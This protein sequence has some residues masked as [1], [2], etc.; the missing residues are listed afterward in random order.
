MRLKTL[1]GIICLLLAL[2]SQAP[3]QSTI[4][5]LP[6]GAVVLETQNLPALGQRTRTMVLWMLNP[7]KNFDGYGADDIYTCPDYT[8][9]SY[10]SGPGRVSLVNTTTKTIINTIKIVGSDEYG[11]DELELPYAIRAGYYYRIATPARKGVE[12]KPTILW[13]RDYNGDG[14][15]LEFALFAAEACMGLQT[16]LIGYSERQ[17]KVIQ[18]P[19]HLNVSEGSNHSDRMSFW[20]DYLFN[21]KPRRPGFWKYEIDYRGRAGSLDKWEVSY[22]AVKEQFEGKVTMVHDQEAPPEFSFSEFIK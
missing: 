16:T 18:Y 17:D 4:H 11:G 7:K 20:A 19:V 5:G 15:A 22:D 14:K 21:S 13:L 3:A 12:A 6:A 9:G 10:Y 1:T 8:R 2:A